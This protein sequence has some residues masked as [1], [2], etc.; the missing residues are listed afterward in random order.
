MPEQARQRVFRGAFLRG[1]DGIGALVLTPEAMTTQI[2]INEIVAQSLAERPALSQLD[3]AARAAKDFEDGL[4]LTDEMRAML[5]GSWTIGGARPK[6]IL[7]DDRPGAARGASVIAKFDSRLDSRASC[8]RSPRA[9]TWSP[10]PGRS[11]APQPLPNGFAE[12]PS[13]ACPG[14]WSRPGRSTTWATP[15]HA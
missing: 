2:E 7:R 11:P 5:G 15:S 6:A 8:V 13:R 1:A 9:S 12:A 14:C 3:R 4:D 10:W